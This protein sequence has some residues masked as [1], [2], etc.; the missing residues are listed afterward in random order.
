MNNLSEIFAAI[1]VNPL[2]QTT[3]PDIQVTGITLDSRKVTPGDIF[4]AVIGG[5]SDGHTFI[6]KAIENGAAAIIGSKSL[7]NDLPVPY[8]QV[9]NPRFTLAHIA[10]ALMDFPARKMTIIG[11][12]G[13]DGKTTTATLLYHI[14]KQAGIK[15]GLIT[16]VSMTIG[17]EELDTGFHVTTPEAVDV[18]RYLAQMA[19]GGMTHVVL[20]T[21]SHG[22]AQNRV[23]A[24]EFDIGIITNITHEHLDYHGSY[25][26]YQAAKGMLFED[27]SR[28]KKKPFKPP[29]LAVLNKD[30]QSYVFLKQ[31]IDAPFQSYSISDPT[32]DVFASEI[33]HQPDGLHF[34]L[35]DSHGTFPIA[36]TLIGNFNISNI[37][38]AYT[39]AV[40]GL[41]I[42]PTVAAKGIAA[43]AG[44]PGR[45]E[46]INMGQEFLAVVDFAHTPNGLK[47]ALETLKEI[48]P[49]DG[50]IWAVFGSAGLRDRE[51]RA[52]MAEVSAQFSDITILTAEDPRA[53]S[54]DDILS[55]MSNAAKS[56]G[57]IQGQNLWS[58]PDRGKAIQFA[59]RNADKA[60][61]VCAFGKGHEQSMCFGTTEHAWDDRTAMRAALAKHLG[62][63]GPEL[64]CL[65]TQD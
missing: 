21:T 45:M 22:L 33:H 28:Q 55:V 1:P 6:S 48:V 61:I 59:V 27:V 32:G 5:S 8:L 56:K 19:A 29:T 52:M 2:N 54:L 42:S 13:T 62:V 9:E 46:R 44:V 36:S 39:A 12:T 34:S 40:A 7:N 30:D 37:L 35:H 17:D 26:A 47:V 53:E 64:P 38:A 41:G 16:T 50:R 58:I 4:V 23:T 10:A 11:V 14:L 15:A 24:C 3:L 25:E 20:E 63:D 43:M 51:K 57:A 65:P 31:L 49:K 18:Q 60:D